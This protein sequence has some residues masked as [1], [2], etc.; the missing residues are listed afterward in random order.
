M[1][2]SSQKSLI[3]RN[4]NT[5]VLNDCSYNFII[6]NDLSLKSKDILFNIFKE[7]SKYNYQIKMFDISKLAMKIV[8]RFSKDKLIFDTIITVG[9]GGKHFFESIKNN[10]IFLDKEII[11]LKWHRLWNKE[12]SLGF[13]TDILDYDLKGKKVLLMEDVIAS[14]STLITLNNEIKK[15]GGK[16]VAI[17]ASLIQ[18]TSLFIEKSFASTY[19]AMKINKTLDITLDPFWYPPIYSLRHLLYGDEEMNDFYKIL[20]EKYFNNE[21]KIEKLIKYYR[22]EIK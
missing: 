15:R 19:V 22:E 12:E 14:G 20:C 11:N 3:K 16:V 9:T 21:D 10:K 6:L 5:I 18:E 7:I 2:I 8:K 13:E 4:S 17:V 1:L